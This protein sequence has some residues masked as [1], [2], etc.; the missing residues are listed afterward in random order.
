GP[1][2]KL[3][4]CNGM[5]DPSH[6]LIARVHGVALRSAELAVAARELADSCGP[7]DGCLSF[8]VL[9]QPGARS[10]LVLVS[11]WR[12]EKDLRAHFASA[13]YGRYVSAVTDLLTRPSDVTIYS[14]SGTVHPIPDLSMEPQRAS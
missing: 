14:I 1:A 11:A 2:A 6:L 4:R 10:E 5:P 8:D 13:A 9:V 7:Q 3:R 12:S